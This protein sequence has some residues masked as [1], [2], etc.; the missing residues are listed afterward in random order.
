MNDDHEAADSDGDSDF[1]E[2]DLDL[3]KYEGSATAGDEQVGG[4]EEDE[5]E[6]KEEDDEDD[7]TEEASVVF[8][9]AQ[10]C[11]D[12]ADITATSAYFPFLQPWPSQVIPGVVFTALKLTLKMN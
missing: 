4:G 9:V 10:S 11:S 3:S 7:D 8:E 2:N 5:D 1:A 6:D 12:A